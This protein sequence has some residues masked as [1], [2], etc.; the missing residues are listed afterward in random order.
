ML[1]A[2]KQAFK[3]RET[4]EPEGP[5]PLVRPVEAPEPFPVG[6]LGPLRVP[7]QAIQSHTR[8]PIE[9][10]AQAVLGAVALVGQAH[11]DVVLPS[12]QAR[13]LSLF[14]MTIA[15]SGERKS[16]VD[17]LALR[18]IYDYEED[19]RAAHRADVKQ[20]EIEKALWDTQQAAAKAGVKAAR[21]KSANQA[22]GAE[23]DLRALGT[24]PEPPLM[25]VLVCPEPTFEGYCK[26]TAIGQPSMGLFSAEGG[27]FIGGHG[28][29]V[30]QRLKTAAGV[31]TVWDGEPIKRVRAGDGSIVLD[32][33]RLSLHLMA[34][35]DVAA[36]LLDDDLLLNQG[37]LS[38]IL[39]VFP[40]ST[41]GQRFF[42]EA[43]PEARADLA[44]Y[45]DRL[46][47]F[48]RAPIPLRAETRN[49]LEPRQLVLT[50][51]AAQVWI[52][53]H[54]FVE[55]RLAADGELVP[56]AGLANKAAEHAARIAGNVTLWTD[57]AATQIEVADMV[58]ACMLVRHYLSE[59][60]RL[61]AMASTHRHLILAQRVLDWL[62]ERWEEPAIYPAVI[63]NDCTIREVRDRRTAL[64]IISTLEEHGWLIR[65]EEP[66]LIAGSV[67]REAWLIHGRTL[68]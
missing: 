8:A 44:R 29:G 31:S 14:L 33:R 42:A 49:E 36:Q 5:R 30:D 61:R 63:Y 11:A 17:R 51:E 43:P 9:I 23:A 40:T 6:A 59:A 13:P 65:L 4:V 28:M 67:R 1:E 32:G 56:I 47:A 25:P 68:R 7:A 62:N 37:L 21:K 52:N 38:R 60:L 54:D 20:F 39:V 26:L 24:G 35:P 16:A 22:F 53:L 15:A 45:K 34:Q 64:K 27:S 57:I 19:L 10:C 2:V 58:N 18:S 66:V 46:A 55:E 48:V 3:N 12:G 41:A 50:P